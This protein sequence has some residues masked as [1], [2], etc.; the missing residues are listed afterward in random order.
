MSARSRTDPAKNRDARERG[1]NGPGS[2]ADAANDPE[3]APEPFKPLLEPWK[4]P[5]PGADIIRAECLLCAKNEE[6]RRM[7][8]REH[9]GGFS[10]PLPGIAERQIEIANKGF[11]S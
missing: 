6:K 4:A 7:R 8:R 5:P 10:P 9:G 2:C 1:V 3:D 11:S